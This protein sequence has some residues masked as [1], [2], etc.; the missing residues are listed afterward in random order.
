MLAAPAPRRRPVC[1]HL[2]P[3]SSGFAFSTRGDFLRRSTD[4]QAQI[5]TVSVNTGPYTLSD[6]LA[7]VLSDTVRGVH[8]KLGLLRLRDHE[9][10]CHLAAF[11][12]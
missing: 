9:R 12:L 7:T 4:R 6:R 3:V 2:C 8:P 1:V 5:G 11:P 10:L